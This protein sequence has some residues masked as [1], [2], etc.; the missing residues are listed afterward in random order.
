MKKK[1]LV[2]ESGPQPKII[3]YPWKSTRYQLPINY[4]STR[5]QFDHNIIKNMNFI[6]NNSAKFQY[7]IITSIL[8]Q[9][10]VP[11]IWN[12]LSFIDFWLMLM[13]CICDSWTHHCDMSAQVS[14]CFGHGQP[15]E[16]TAHGHGCPCQLLIWSWVACKGE[17]LCAS[18]PIMKCWCYVF[19]TVAPTFTSP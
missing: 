9:P 1:V 3:K 17:C 7:N 13:L 14:Y 2:K 5:C 18:V 6:K 8:C 4:L 19:V 10:N 16:K 15:A 11:Q 12:S